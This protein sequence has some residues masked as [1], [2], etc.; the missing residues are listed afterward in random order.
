VNWIKQLTV[1]VNAQNYISFA[2]HRGYNPENGDTTYP[3]AKTLIFGINAK[4]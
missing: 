2:N 3:W 4:F 1:Y